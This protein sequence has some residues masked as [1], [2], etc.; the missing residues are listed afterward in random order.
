MTFQGWVDD[1]GGDFRM[2]SGFHSKA[3]T[4]NVNSPP[5]QAWLEKVRSSL[6]D[7]DAC[8]EVIVFPG[9]VPDRFEHDGETYEI[10]PVNVTIGVSNDA[11]EAFHNQAVLA[12]AQHRIMSAELKISG[13]AL[14]DTKSGF[15]FLDDLDISD[16]QKYSVTSFEL[17]NTRLFD[18]SKGRVRQVRRDRDEGY[19]TNI[20]VLIT[21]AGYRIYTEYAHVHGIGCNGHVVKS[22]RKEPYEGAEVVIEFKEFE[23]NSFLELPEKAFFGEFHYWPRQSDETDSSASFSFDLRYVP[24]DARDLLI[25]LLNGESQ[26]RVILEINL[27]SE[28]EELLAAT[29]MFQGKVRSYSFFVQHTL[30]YE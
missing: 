17:A 14:P 30:S 4:L 12:V 22:L 20:S 5:D 27:S 13:E 18:H 2:A 16:T 21:D 15:I 9:V 26:K 25:P 24:E 29:N 8:G 19:G 1:P 6:S 3:C 28:K 10:E 7:G 23:S 11:F